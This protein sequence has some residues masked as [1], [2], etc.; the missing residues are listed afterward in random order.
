[1]TV[2]SY[3]SGT[4]SGQLCAIADGGTPNYNYVWN[5]ALGQTGTCAFN[6]TANQYTVLV[7][8]ERNC[9]ATVSYNLDSITNSMDPDSVTMTIN[10]VKCFGAFDGSVTINNI[11]GAVAPY[12]YS[13]TGPNSYNSTLSSISSL[14][15]GSYAV[16]IEDSNGCA[17]TVNAEVMQPDQLEY[18]T[19]NVEGATCLGACNGEIHIDVE[20]GTWPYYYDVDEQGSFPLFN[21][22]QLINDTIIDNLCAGLHSI[23]ITDGNNCEGTVVW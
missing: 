12:T 15:A 23:Y 11:V 5:D 22:V 17:I 16:A 21:T 3:C 8:D 9:I 14:Y 19:Y 6:L 20:G 7:M 18:T 10:D 4:N 1:M 2:Y 13:W